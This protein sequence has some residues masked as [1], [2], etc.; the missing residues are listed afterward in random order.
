M[1]IEG[2][3][4]D[5]T[6]Y[7]MRSR[8]PNVSIFLS[9]DWYTVSVCFYGVDFV[10]ASNYEVRFESFNNLKIRNDAKKS[11]L[12]HT[13]AITTILIGL[14]VSFEIVNEWLSDEDVEKTFVDD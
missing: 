9:E 7:G 6:E 2:M 11:V 10:D 5:L 13:H 12:I 4:H 1:N 8:V 3:I 14:G